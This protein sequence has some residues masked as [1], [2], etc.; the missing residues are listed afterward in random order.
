MYVYIYA[1]TH[2]HKYNNPISQNNPAD[3]YASIHYFISH[4]A[5]HCPRYFFKMLKLLLV[6]HTIMI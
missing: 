4:L 6:L 2:I 1:H 3:S 5:I